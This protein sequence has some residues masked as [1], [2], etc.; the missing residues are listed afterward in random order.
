[1]RLTDVEGLGHGR[2]VDDQSHP[3]RSPRGEALDQFLCH[4]RLSINTA[5]IGVDH[6][7]RGYKLLANTRSNTISPH[8]QDSLIRSPVCKFGCNSILVLF[9][10]DEFLPVRDVLLNPLPEQISQHSPASQIRRRATPQSRSRTTVRHRSVNCVEVRL[11]RFALGAL[12]LELSPKFWSEDLSECSC[13]L[14][15]DLDTVALGSE[16]GAWVGFKI[17]KGIELKL[18]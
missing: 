7:M 13:T 16:I 8:D 9:I 11:S 17:W 4:W 18:F 15:I 14:S 2:A 10:S 5:A 1:M 12:L 6:L 3:F